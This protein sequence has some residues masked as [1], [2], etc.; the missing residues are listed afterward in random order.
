LWHDNGPGRVVD[1]TIQDDDDDTVIRIRR[2]GLSIRS[3]DIVRKSYAFH[4]GT[5]G[6]IS[7]DLEE[8]W[9]K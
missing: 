9:W 5:D 1:F 8:F 3:G 7:P 4:Y 6:I 2:E